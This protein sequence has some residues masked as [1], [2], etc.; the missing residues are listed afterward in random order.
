[1]HL[2]KINIRSFTHIHIKK[3]CLMKTM[4]KLLLLSNTFIR[5]TKKISVYYSLLIFWP[6]K[7]RLL[8]E[9][10]TS[11]LHS[12]GRRMYVNRLSIGSNGP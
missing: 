8:D 11:C 6:I 7:A 12:F 9:S 1:M 2:F 5:G 3:E 4:T 10:K